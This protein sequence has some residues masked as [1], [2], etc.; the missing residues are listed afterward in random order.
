MK[1]NS[2]ILWEHLNYLATHYIITISSK[3]RRDFICASNAGPR[4]LNWDF[5]L[6]ASSGN[7][8]EA[9]DLTPKACFLTLQSSFNPSKMC[10]F[11]IDDSKRL[12][13][14]LNTHIDTQMSEHP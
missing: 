11:H 9:G 12:P 10:T 6:A 2:D 13:K 4:L 1:N 7:G 8:D 3:M 14:Y 5:N